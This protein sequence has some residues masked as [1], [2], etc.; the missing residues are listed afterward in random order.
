MAAKEQIYPK[1][2]LDKCIRK[3]ENGYQLDVWITLRI[4]IDVEPFLLLTLN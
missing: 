1:P 4:R 3:E 2:S